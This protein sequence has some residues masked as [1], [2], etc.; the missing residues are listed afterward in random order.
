M[1][2]IQFVCE[3]EKAT[4]LLRAARLYDEGLRILPEWIP[5]TQEIPPEK[6]TIDAVEVVRCKDC[7]WGTTPYGDEHDGWTKC[8]NLPGK[9]LMH[10]ESFCSY[11]ERRTDEVQS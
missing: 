1:T 9:P 3:D 7:R 11:G 8:N 10:D 4:F 2:N 6:P 5:V